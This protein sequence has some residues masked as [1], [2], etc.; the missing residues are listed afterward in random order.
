MNGITL[1]GVDSLPAGWQFDKREDEI[2][3][4]YFSHIDWYVA[5]EL[6]EVP[7]LSAACTA[8][9][10]E[11]CFRQIVSEHGFTGLR[12]RMPTLRPFQPLPFTVVKGPVAHLLL[13]TQRV[14]PRTLA[15]IASRAWEQRLHNVHDVEAFMRAQPEPWRILR[16]GQVVTRDYIEDR[17]NVHVDAEGRVL[18]VTMG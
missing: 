13:N 2:P 4:E 5:H 18:R 11:P 3:L 15:R 7:R 14:D 1:F 8:G 6:T 12:A 10:E 17:V 9:A 16:P